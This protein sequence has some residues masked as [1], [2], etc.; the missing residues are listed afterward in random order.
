M[1][2]GMLESLN[3]SQSLIGVSSHLLIINGDRSDGTF[4]VN[5]KES[6]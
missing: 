1:L 2:V 5:D 3:D 6:S 4:G